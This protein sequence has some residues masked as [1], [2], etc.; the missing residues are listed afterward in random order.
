M[1]KITVKL[2]PVIMRELVQLVVF[3]VPK[4][5]AGGFERRACLA[6]VHR[7][8]TKANAQ[9]VKF[10]HH[11]GAMLL[12]AVREDLLECCLVFV[13]AVVLLHAATQQIEVV[14]SAVDNEPPSRS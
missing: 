3:I 4:A 7:V 9:F 1:D 5:A 11:D 12:V 6:G 14:V 8:R 13:P 10:A 2:D